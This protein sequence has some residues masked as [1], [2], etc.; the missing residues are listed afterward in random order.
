MDNSKILKAGMRTIK[1][2]KAS[3][4]LYQAVVENASKYEGG[5]DEL[6]R[7]AIARE[8][9]LL[10]DFV[11]VNLDDL[12]NR[13]M[14]ISAKVSL[15]TM[16]CISAQA[17]Q[18]NVENTEFAGEILERFAS[19]S[20][21]AEGQILENDEQAHIFNDFKE[22]CE[23]LFL[24]NADESQSFTDFME[25]V[26]RLGI[27]TKQFELKHQV[28]S[29]GYI[30]NLETRLAQY[31]NPDAESKKKA[32]IIQID[33]VVDPEVKNELISFGFN[34]DKYITHERESK[35][36]GIIATV[37]KSNDEIE[38]QQIERI[39]RLVLENKQ[40]IAEQTEIINASV[41]LVEIYH[42]SVS[43]FG[44]WRRRTPEELASLFP[45]RYRHLFK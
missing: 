41:K 24:K 9:G 1:G 38:K 31:E 18:A 43:F 32:V 21:I 27:N 42:K 14:T 10:P 36:E 39:E 30:E 6:C 34:E 44:I 13:N 15:D 17:D 23:T 16:H 8:V 37:Q 33:Q 40:L 7:R 29:L 28:D 5:Q 26:L 25:D 19:S 2:V 35:L 45:Q 3:D 11:T 12:P 20:V 4:E 22:L